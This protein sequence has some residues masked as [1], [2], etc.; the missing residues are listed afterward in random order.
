[1]NGLDAAS[2][3]TVRANGLDV[4]VRHIPHRATS[5]TAAVDEA[6][7]RKRACFLCRENLYPEQKGVGFGADDTLYANPFPI[8][9]RHLTV[10]HREHRPQ[11][12]E[13]QVGV[14]LDLAEALP[15]SFVVYNGPEC[16]ASAPDH[17]H[18]QAGSRNG[19]PIARDVAGLGGSEIRLYGGRA[20]LLRGGDRRGMEEKTNRAVETLADVTGKRPE[21]LCNVMTFFEPE[22]GWTTIL[23]PRGKHRP[24]AFHRGELTV[25]PAAIDLCG[26]LVAPVE[27]DFERISGDDVAAVFRE[28]SL[29]EEQ[30]REVSRRLEGR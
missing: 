22:A 1:V 7:I 15:D 13:G 24:D 28:V 6:S 19:L 17:K 8:V 3:R 16:G 14:M 9:E 30:F 4:L 5:T 27:K 12:I 23:F 2:T 10:V 26:I 11:R 18:L 29:A 21:P 20:L 25:S